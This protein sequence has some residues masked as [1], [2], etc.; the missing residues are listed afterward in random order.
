MSEPLPP[1]VE[2]ADVIKAYGVPLPLRIRRLTVAADDCIALGG[3]DAGAAEMLL[4]L[5]TGAAV[6]DEGAVRVAG[7]D[8]RAI[9]TDTEWLT[10]LDRF[11]IV[12]ARAVLIG[13]LPIA[14][15]LA[16]PLTLSID[17]MSSETRE[18]VEALADTVGLAHERLRDAAST[19]TPIE[20]V[21]VH[22]AR[23]LAP[24]PRLLLLEH[25]TAGLRDEG[26]SRALGTTL[27]RA[28]ER[29]TVGWLAL[30]DDREF[31]RAAGARLVKLH[32]QTGEVVPDSFWRRLVT[33]S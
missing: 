24:R 10:S 1:L 3:L 18:R 26:A 2:V 29:A 6:P 32:A 20:T 8:T 21:R 16:L 30:T 25:P 12:T 28:A 31:A 9:A 27:R 17:P 11:G 33:R 13:A 19:L 5:I 23:A 15:N 22:L 7:Q 4:N 14:A